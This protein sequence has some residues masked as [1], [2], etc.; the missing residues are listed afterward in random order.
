M[1]PVLF[2]P[3][4]HPADCAQPES[5]CLQCKFFQRC[6]EILLKEKKNNTAEVQAE[7]VKNSYGSLAWEGPGGED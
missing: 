4:P 7:V 3:P 1:T 5:Y 2:Q 6:R